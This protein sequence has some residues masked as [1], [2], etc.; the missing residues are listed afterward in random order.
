MLSYIIKRL[1]VLIPILLGVSILTF[2]L[3][4][5]TPGDPAR[6][7][8]RQQ[9]GGEDPSPAAVEQIREEM[10]LNQP[11]HVQ[12]YD[13][14]KG[15][16]KGDLGE[17]MVTGNPV[18]QEIMRVFPYTLKLSL[19]SM[20]VAIGIAV[21]IGIMSALKHN[22]IIDYLS[23]IGALIGVSMPNFW[24]ALLLMLVFSIHLGIFPVY[25]SGGG[26]ETLILPGIT[27][28]TGMAAMTTRLIRSSMLD[29]LMQEYTEFAKAKGL[30]NWEVINKHALKNAMIP[31]ITYLGLQ[32]GWA[33]E[34]AVIVE[35]IFARPGIGRLLYDAVSA[36]DFPVIQGVVLYITVVFVM[37]NLLI[38]VLYVLIDP[39]IKYNKREI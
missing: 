28:G 30:S 14:L 20:L 24:L 2:S 21:P 29:V 8:L 4:Y 7:A 6:Q 27:L 31:V 15:A 35:N 26:I 23:M 10:G 19:F 39:R 11:L 1:L 18:T 5:F 3:V 13:W 25:G 12:Y 34:G 33:F 22:S 36:R 17:S 16:V 38:D 9:M 37:V 32:L